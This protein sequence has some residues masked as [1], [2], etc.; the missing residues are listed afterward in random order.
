MMPH[1]FVI[2]RI[3]PMGGRAGIIRAFALTPYD[4]ELLTTEVHLCGPGARLEVTVGGDDGDLTA[5]TAVLASIDARAVD[6]CVGLAAPRA[7]SL[8]RAFDDVA[9][10]RARGPTHVRRDR[11]LRGVHDR[12]TSKEDAHVPSMP[13]GR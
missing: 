10:G 1:A 7:D 11:R 2:V 13:C 3:V 6:V 8:R 4:L 5:V 12:A 9:R